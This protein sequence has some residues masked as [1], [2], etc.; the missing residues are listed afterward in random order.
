MV[1]AIAATKK[2]RNNNDEE[3]RPIGPKDGGPTVN[4]VG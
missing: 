1:N 4:S 2:F 3:K